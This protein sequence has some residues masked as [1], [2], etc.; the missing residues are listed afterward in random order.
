MFRFQHSVVTKA[1][2]SLAWEVFSDVSKWN[3]FAD[4]YGAISW[5]EGKPWEAKSRMEIEVLRPIPMLINRVMISCTPA[6]RVGWIDHSGAKVLAQWLM[7]EDHPAGGTRVHTW[8]D[9][10]HSGEKIMNQ[11][12]EDV[13]SHFIKVWYENFRTYCD[14]LALGAAAMEY[15]PLVFAQNP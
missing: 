9:L 15:S 2:R 7:F 6:G 11:P 12:V 13:F 14:A 4:I 5:R 10:L 3:S 1:Q 8:G